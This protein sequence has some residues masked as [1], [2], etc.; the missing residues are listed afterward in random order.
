MLCGGHF[1]AHGLHAPGGY[2]NLPPT[3]NNYYHTDG[4]YTI[5]NLCTRDLSCSGSESGEMVSTRHLTVRSGYV[6]A[7]LFVPLLVAVICS[8]AG[9]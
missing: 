8:L 2:D 1:I 4:A 9:N 6:A 5:S 7:L 3:H